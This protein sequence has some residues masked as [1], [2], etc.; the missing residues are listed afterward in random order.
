MN[1]PGARFQGRDFGVSKRR[2]AQV[3]AAWLAQCGPGLASSSVAIGI[4]AISQ[5]LSDQCGAL[6]VASSSRV[7]LA[8]QLL[9]CMPDHPGL[10]ADLLRRAVPITSD[11][12]QNQQ[13]A[14]FRRIAGN[15]LSQLRNAADVA[16][17]NVCLGAL[18]GGREPAWR[19]ERLLRYTRIEAQIDTFARWLEHT[20]RSRDNATFSEAETGYLDAVFAGS[21]ERPEDVL[22]ALRERRLAVPVDLLYRWSEFAQSYTGRVGFFHGTKARGASG[23]RVKSR[24]GSPGS[25]VGG[26]AAVMTTPAPDGDCSNQSLPKSNRAKLRGRSGDYRTEAG[27]ARIVDEMRRFE[28]RYGYQSTLSEPADQPMIDARDSV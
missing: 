16:S 28:A 22:H 8:A 10:F 27:V 17:I 13:G 4:D 11:V 25:P 18:S 7:E 3:L 12:P 6:G 26:E 23:T 15:Y 20:L 1:L 5:K 21:K 24:D 9:R 19:R 2:A 14:H